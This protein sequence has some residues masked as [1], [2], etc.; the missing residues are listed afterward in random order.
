[1][2]IPVQ[3]VYH[4]L[5]YA[6]DQLEA[7][8]Q[9]AVTAEAEDGLL[10]LLA[11]V[12]I[13]GTTHLLK[14]G[15]AREYV[16]HEELTGR[17]RGKLL[18][19]DSIRQQTLPKAQAWCA[20]DELSHDTLPNRLLKATLYRL[21]TADE[22]DRSLARELRAL[23]YRL[24]DVPLQPVRDLR[25]FEQVRLNRNTAHY[26][27]LLSVCQLVHEQAMLSQ[28]TGERLFQ[29]F[30]RNEA[31]MARLFERFV[32]NFY[33]RKQQVYSVQAE[34]LT[35]GLRA[36]D[37]ASQA[38]LPVMRT[39][40]SLTAA[41]GKIILDCKYYRQ[42]LVRHHAR[43]RIISAHLYQLYAYLQHGQP[44][45]RLVPLEAIL[46]Y[47]VTV[48]AYRFGYEVAGTDHK[49]RVET[50]NLDQPWRE[51]ERELLTVIGL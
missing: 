6:W 4:L 49:M 12:L 20:F 41:T 32:R 8:D 15:L 44:A 25:I 42:A 2:S 7:A 39:D 9:V 19:A 36:Q 23:Y 33:H 50:V 48:K 16:E 38:V 18:L 24:G 45:K 34:Q 26:G 14:R 37:E 28:Q 51:V 13:Q 43:E 46:L 29:D 27:L 11:R 21:F 35:W 5:V 47:P 17:L 30:A 3:N 10:E 1:M 40:V 22:L 31:Q